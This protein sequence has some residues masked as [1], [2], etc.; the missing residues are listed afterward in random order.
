MTANAVRAQSEWPRIT[1]SNMG[2]HLVL[3]GTRKHVNQIVVAIRRLDGDQSINACRFQ[4]RVYYTKVRIQQER[5]EISQA[6]SVR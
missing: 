1:P 6:K 2:A 3:N 5:E 4:G